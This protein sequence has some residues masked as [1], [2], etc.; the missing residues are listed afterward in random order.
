MY[1]NS[2]EIHWLIY[3]WLLFKKTMS[4]NLNANIIRPNLSWIILD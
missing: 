3:V 2:V 4:V 1:V